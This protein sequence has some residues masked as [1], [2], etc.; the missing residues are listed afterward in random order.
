[1]SPPTPKALLFDLG[2]VLVDIKFS[3]AIA[4]WARYSKLPVDELQQK[5][6]YD[7]TYESHERGEIEAHEYFQ[8]LALTLELDASTEEIERG[9]NSIFVGEIEATR[10]LVEQARM[11]VPCFAFTNTNASHMATWS[12]LYPGVVGAFDRIFASHQLRLRKPEKEAFGR[13]CDLISVAAY[14]IVFFD[15]LNENVEAALDA[16]LRAVLVRSPE[17]VSHAINGL[18]LGAVNSGA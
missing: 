4:A 13:I 17:D 1:M 5:F 11:H 16:G 14:D 8:H 10:R 9:W 12:R 2:G 15:D 3:R 18:G 6:K 7:A